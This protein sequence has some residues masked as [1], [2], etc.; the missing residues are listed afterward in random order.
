MNKIQ[1]FGVFVLKRIVPLCLVVILLLF[2]PTLS[3]PADGNLSLIYNVFVGQKS[4]YQGVV[5]VWNIDTFESG[6]SSKTSLLNSAAAMFQKENKGLYVMIRNVT[7]NECL[8]MLKDGQK[9]DVFSCSYGVAEKIYDYVDVLNE[10]DFNLHPNFMDAGRDEKGLFKAAAWC[11]GSYYLISTKANLEKAGVNF[12]GDVSLLDLALKLG[13]EKTSKKN[14]TVVYS[15]EFGMGGYLSPQTS[16]LAYNE[17]GELSILPQSF[18]KENLLQT[19][20]SAYCRFVAGKSVVLLGTSKDVERMN[21]RLKQGRISDLIVFP[22]TKFTDLV[23]FAFVSVGEDDVKNEYKQKFVQFLTT[24]KFQK[25]VALSNHLT[26]TN[27]DFNVA[28]LGVMQHITLDNCSD[29]SLNDVFV[30]KQQIDELRNILF[31]I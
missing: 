17:T 29:Y 26:V 18:S 1:K 25:T 31:E 8:N 24:Q 13:Y 4:K 5:E 22:L 19:S 30:S 16:L 10:R 14:K 20:Y 6:S 27:V 12:E 23:Q 7:E 28:E 11:A 21:N 15:L 3:V 9:P 2:V